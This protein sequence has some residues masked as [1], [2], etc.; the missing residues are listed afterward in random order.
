M[1]RDELGTWQKCI[2]V[3][4]NHLKNGKS[5]VVDNTNPD[6]DS[7]YSFY[8]FRIYW[9]SYRKRYIE[10]AK[11]MKV[12]CRCFEIICHL[13]QA[14]HNIRY[15]SLTA[16]RQNEVSIMVLRMFQKNFVVCFLYS[17]LYV[18]VTGSIKRRRL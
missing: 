6:I 17:D 18:N 9:S 16:K 15:R 11:E 3:A 10:L 8:L 1:F 14:R 13:D 12:K 7:R 2:A 4:R 5:V